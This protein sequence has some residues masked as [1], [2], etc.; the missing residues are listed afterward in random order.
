MVR[1]SSRFT[2]TDDEREDH[3]KTIKERLK[4]EKSKSEDADSKLGEPCVTDYKTEIE[5]L[6]K[7]CQQETLPIYTDREVKVEEIATSTERFSW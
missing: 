5:M 2:M 1:N 7:E 6:T 3:K 4:R